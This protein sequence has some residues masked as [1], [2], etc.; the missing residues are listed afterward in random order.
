M[1][2]VNKIDRNNNNNIGINM[3]MNMGLNNSAIMKKS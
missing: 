1:E 3:N 2:S